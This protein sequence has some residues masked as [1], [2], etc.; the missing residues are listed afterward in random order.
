M[1]NQPLTLIMAILTVM[2]GAALLFVILAVMMPLYGM[3]QQ[4]GT[5]Y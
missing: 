3:Y 4:I 1:R 2:V 5:G